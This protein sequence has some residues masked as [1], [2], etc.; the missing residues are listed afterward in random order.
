ML[1]LSPKINKK[2]AQLIFTTHDIS[3]L[4]EDL[5]RKDQI[6]FAEKDEQGVS[7]FYSLQDFDNVRED[8]PFD[9]WYMAGKFGGLPNIGEI[10][11]IFE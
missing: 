4:D 2:N 10:E 11:K 5:L 1:F 8:I 3:L 9:K 7:D 6:W